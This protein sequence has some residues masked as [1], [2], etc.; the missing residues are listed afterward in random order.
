MELLTCLKNPVHQDKFLVQSEQ[1]RK[2]PN[3]KNK[4][5]PFA[6]N[7]MKRFSL[8]VGF[9]IFSIDVENLFFDK[10]VETNILLNYRLKKK[11]SLRKDVR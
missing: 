1:I 9:H 11:N 3:E 2:P 6:F 8:R 7:S 5:F 4:R 10:W